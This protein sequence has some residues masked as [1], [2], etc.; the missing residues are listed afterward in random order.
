[1]IVYLLW[2]DTTIHEYHD[3][4]RD[5][6]SELLDIYASEGLA[7]LARQKLQDNDPNTYTKTGR[8]RIE[9]WVISKIPF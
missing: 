9:P 1:M 2:L 4:T 6:D 5:Y 7:R 3:G 8:L